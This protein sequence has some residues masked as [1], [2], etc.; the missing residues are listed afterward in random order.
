[1]A[2]LLAYALCDLDDVKEL[3]GISGSSQDN[4]ITRKINQATEMIEN[5]CGRR[6]KSTIYTDIE[7]DSTGTNQIILNQ[8]PV[9]LLSSLSWRDTSLNEA[10]W[11]ASDTEYYFLDEA[12][13]VLDLNFT[14][15]GNW[16]R[17][18]VTYTA[19]YSEIPADIVEA[20]ATLAGHLVQTPISVAATGVRVQAEGGRRIEYFDTSSSGSTRN[21]IQQLGIDA[22]L[23]PYA[24]MPI[25]ADK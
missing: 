20:C 15:W 13:G 17:F 1:M 10:D 7:Y 25:L 4:L 19:G 3:L 12:S 8:R 22:I 11:E 24:N 5:F 18:K 9:T 23:E 2:T 14:T 6:F 21:L 16:N